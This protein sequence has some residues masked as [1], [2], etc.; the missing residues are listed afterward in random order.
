MRVMARR[1]CGMRASGGGKQAAC[2]MRDDRVARPH[3]WK[4]QDAVLGICLLLAG[5]ATSA[6]TGPALQA[7]TLLPP[8]AGDAPVTVWRHDDAGTSLPPTLAFEMELA[9]GGFRPDGATLVLQ[10]G[11]NEGDEDTSR[12]RVQVQ[13]HTRMTVGETERV[14]VALPGCVS[15]WI[16]ATPSGASAFVLPVPTPA[17][18]TCYPAYPRARM[19]Q[20]IRNG[21]EPGFETLGEWAIALWREDTNA[22][23]VEIDRVHIRIDSLRGG[24]WLPL[25]TIEAR[26]F[27]GC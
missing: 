5:A 21:V 4:R 18:E 14:A 25:T 8:T 2:C 15:G 1:R 24:H 3:G 6:N 22:A 11:E 26:I 13:F 27:S 23:M 19:E 10:G 12:Y 9:S 7:I 17:Q 20:A 16:D